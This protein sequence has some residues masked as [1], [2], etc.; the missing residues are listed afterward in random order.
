MSLRSFAS[1]KSGKRK[2]RTSPTPK[3]GVRAQPLIAVRDVRASSR[4]Y[5]KLLG[6]PKLGDLVRESVGL[7][8]GALCGL[9]RVLV[10]LRLLN[11]FLSIRGFSL[12]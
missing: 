5:S 6:V 1:S 8:A 11:S 7:L 10:C 3:I 9:L 12:F 2:Y 4:W